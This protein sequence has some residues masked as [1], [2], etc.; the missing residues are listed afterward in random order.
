MIPG[1]RLQSK[2]E[3]NQC[4]LVADDAERPI[5][6]RIA[7]N[8]AFC[9]GFASA[10]GARGLRFQSTLKIGP[11]KGIDGSI[12][13]SYTNIKLK[14]WIEREATRPRLNLINPF[15][16]FS[17]SLELDAVRFESRGHRHAEP[18]FKIE[19]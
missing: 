15:Q 4:E 2:E 10:A 9:Y 13:I 5:G 16:P 7:R 19:Y 1:L 17:F 11:D 18:P 8:G 14:K 6:M 3:L 12:A